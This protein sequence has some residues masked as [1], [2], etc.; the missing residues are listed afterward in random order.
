M[1]PAV[2]LTAGQTYWLLFASDGTTGTFRGIQ[3]NQA[4]PRLLDGSYFA[5]T[6]G[7]AFPLGASVAIG[8]TY[9][10]KIPLVIFR[11]A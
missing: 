2:A 6:I 8:S 9:S 4:L 5:R 11:E 3:P 7:S 10:Q 1:S